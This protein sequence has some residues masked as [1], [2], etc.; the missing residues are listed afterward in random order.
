M[1]E[2][3]GPVFIVGMP[4]SGTKLLRDLL[5]QHP[6]ISIPDVESHFI[7]SLVK[8]FGEKPEIT[9]TKQKE[10]FY[11]EFS[12]TSFFYNNLRKNRPLEK[13]Q[14]IAACDFT[15]WKTIFRFIAIYYSKGNFSNEIIWGIKLRVISIKYYFSI[16]FFQDQSL[17]ILSGIR[18]ISVFRN[19]R[20]GIRIFSDLL[21]TGAKQCVR[22]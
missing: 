5:N 13:D 15:D 9:T 22:Q 16:V 7:P 3:I 17:F 4:R 12:A 8:I 18:V 6:M 1:T 19:E 21:P 14:F 10:N 20:Y 11:R 2:V